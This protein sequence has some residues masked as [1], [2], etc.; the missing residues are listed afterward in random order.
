MSLLKA[1]S[2]IA[3]PRQLYHYTTQHGLIG[4]IEGNTIWATKIQYLN[5]TTEY[6]LALEI[7]I[8]EIKRKKA[9]SVSATNDLLY[10][11]LL[12][13]IDK[14]TGLNTCVCS[15][16]EKEDLLSQWRGYGGGIGGYAVGFNSSNLIAEANKQDFILSSCIYDEKQQ[17]SLLSELIADE[18]KFIKRK[19]KKTDLDD[20]RRFESVAV[21]FCK[22]LAAIA[23][24]IKN[25]KFSE[26]KEWRL[27]SKW[28]IRAG[29]LSF[30]PGMSTLIPFYHFRL[31][32]SPRRYLDKLVIG[33]CP[34]PELTE[35]AIL[36]ML[37]KYNA[38]RVNI[39]RSEI[40][41]RNM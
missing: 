6:K 7:A 17:K 24:T 18:V 8:E 15:F 27:I 5:D 33:P 34:H 30:R 29:H 40:P 23:P 14:M 32:E 25:K 39:I 4:I 9:E 20:P 10:Q 31:G 1:I 35:D 3:P 16:S 36:R 22:N 11:R 21:D 28:G 2:S 12:E 41:F 38:E 19:L 13:Q 26:E 37:Q